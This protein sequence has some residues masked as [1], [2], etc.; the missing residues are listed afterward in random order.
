MTRR[1][2]VC[3]E[4]EQTATCAFEKHRARS[5]IFRNALRAVV[6]RNIY[7]QAAHKCCSPSFLLWVPEKPRAALALKML[8][9]GAKNLTQFSVFLQMPEI[10]VCR[11]WGRKRRWADHW[12]TGG[13]GHSQRVWVLSPSSAFRKLGPQVFVQTGTMC[14]ALSGSLRVPKSLPVALGGV[15]Q[16]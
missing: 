1:V 13:G 7:F 9:S 10:S 6:S 4:V 2:S 8:L 3:F 5:V 12:G 16:R 15:L 11:E 14:M